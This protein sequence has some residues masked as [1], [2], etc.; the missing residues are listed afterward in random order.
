[1]STANSHRFGTLQ[2]VTTRVVIVG[3]GILGLTHAW[4][5][6][7][8]GYE[9]I[10][11]ERDTPVV[12]ASVRNFGLVWVSGRRSGDELR[13]ACRSRELWERIGTDI[14]DV[15]FRANGS[16][17]L[18]TTPQELAVLE[19]AAARPDA[20]DRGFEMC[21]E[22]EVRRR[23]PGIK[24]SC[25]GGLFAGRD[26]TVEP[27]LVPSAFRTALSRSPAYQHRSGLV[28]SDVADHAVVTT[29]GERFRGDRVIVC[30]GAD[31]GPA[32]AERLGE[33]VVQRVLLHMAQTEPL[34]RHL[35]TSVADAN[36]LRYYPCFAG[37]AMELLDPPTDA[38]R[39]YAAQL[40]CVQRLDGTL[41]I[42]DTHST[43][44][45]F[46]F[47]VEEAAIDTIVELATAAIGP[48]FPRLRRRWFGVYHQL[49][50]ANA[51]QLYL[52]AELAEGVTFVGAAGGRGMTCAP[53][54][55]EATFR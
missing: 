27:G 12:G 52:R 10:H 23:N 37:D 18:A 55:A 43:A 11:L 20:V 2:T 42:G 4:Q 35:P 22:A 36:S 50:P 33:G 34:D 15:G 40:L 47:A 41:T 51:E 29:S 6:Q 48:P 7:Q 31:P 38:V 9:V 49:T 39:D 54:I 21:H 19:R 24:G 3:G 45:P 28:I 32:I 44:E 26:A 1:L 25:I 17:T 46:D 5:A 8:M 16:V 13:L 14:P 30:L 53:A